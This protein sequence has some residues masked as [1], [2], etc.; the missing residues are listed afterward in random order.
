MLAVDT[1]VIIRLVT[2]DDPKQAK[3]AAALFAT[4][5]IFLPK[6][7]ML[8]SEWVLRYS[9]ALER[10][11][12]VRSLRGVLGLPGVSA[13]DAVSVQRALDLFERGLDFADA[14]HVASSGAAASFATFDTRLVKRAKAS[15]AANVERA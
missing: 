11:A 5:E 13:E 12:I 10:D 4:N 1:N 6:T 2:N 15:G 3:R 14:L 8:E 7:V 9:Y